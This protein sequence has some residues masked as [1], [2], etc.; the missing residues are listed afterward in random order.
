[1]WYVAVQISRVLNQKKNRRLL[2]IFLCCR[3]F[4]LLVW[5]LMG[6]E[7]LATK[8]CV[9]K[10]NPRLYDST[11]CYGCVKRSSAVPA[12]HCSNNLAYRR[13]LPETL[14]QLDCSSYPALSNF[15]IH[16]HIA[17][18]ACPTT[19]EHVSNARHP[20]PRHH[21][22]TVMHSIWHRGLSA[23]C[24]GAC[25]SEVQNQFQAGGRLSFFKHKSV[26]QM[27]KER[28]HISPHMQQ[29]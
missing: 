12:P 8:L 17:N 22:S 19:I 4:W 28:M 3:S 11:R 27:Q 1:M 5:R 10:D 15:S 13:D 2:R 9:A 16:T 21:P 20:T 6:D 25:K 7:A 18:A 23:S 29:W 24:A 26:L 14:P